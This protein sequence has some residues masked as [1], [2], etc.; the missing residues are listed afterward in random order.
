[1][2][3][4]NGD[5]F[6]AAANILNDRCSPLQSQ[7]SDYCGEAYAGGHTAHKGHVSN[8]GRYRSDPYYFSG[9]QQT[10]Y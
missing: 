1:M 3:V 10:R 9:A 4:T 2:L 7:G 6:G 8:V 5:F